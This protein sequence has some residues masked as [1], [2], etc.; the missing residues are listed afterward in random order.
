[1]KIKHKIF[2]INVLFLL[3]NCI[4]ISDGFSTNGDHQIY[5]AQEILEEMGYDVGKID[6]IWGKKNRDA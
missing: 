1:M 5:K 4:V 6:G 2:Y 3:I